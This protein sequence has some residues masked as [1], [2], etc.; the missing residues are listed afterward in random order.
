MYDHKIGKQTL[1]IEIARPGDAEAICNI[2]DRAWIQTYPNAELG[3]TPEDIT[4]N[5]QGLN[6]EFVPRR[7]AHLKNKLAIAERPD[8]S[9]FVAKVGGK[10]VGFVD[11]SIE[12]GKRRIGALYV[13]PEFQNMGIGSELIQKALDWHGNNDIYLEVVAYNQ[14]AIKFYK[15]LGFS[16]TDT[17]VQE[18]PG[19]PAF[20]KSI[21]VFEMVRKVKN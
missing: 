2:R 5:A 15:H 10:I 16:K 13:D 12:E 21:P 17:V 11:P 1:T 20:M 4:R 14:N 3:I 6:G 8:G 7:I 18:E 19:R 9:T